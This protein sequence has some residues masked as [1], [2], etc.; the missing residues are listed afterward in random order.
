MRRGG[1]QSDGCRSCVATTIIV[2][3]HYV[4]TVFVD[5]ALEEPAGPVHLAS[6]KS[7]IV[8]TAAAL[9]D[10]LASVVEHQVPLLIRTG[11]NSTCAP[12]ATQKSQVS[13]RKTCHNRCNIKAGF[14]KR[15]MPSLDMGGTNFPGPLAHRRVRS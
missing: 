1:G 7:R 6:Q 8:Q 4:A 9:D 14:E 15:A 11:I 10:A 2:C 13:S 12:C 5:D 3:G